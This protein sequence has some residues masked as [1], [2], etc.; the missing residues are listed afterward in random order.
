LL[1][2]QSKKYTDLSDM[3]NMDTVKSNGNI[4]GGPE[5]K[6]GDERTD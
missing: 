6:Q 4:I 5:A 2:I 1:H 3:S